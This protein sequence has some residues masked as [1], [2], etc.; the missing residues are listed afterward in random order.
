MSQYGTQT[1]IAKMQEFFDRSTRCLTEKDSNFAP[2]PG[3]HTVAGQVAHV[4][5]TVDW[6][7]DAAFGGKGFDMDFERHDKQARAVTSLTQARA[8]LAK[9]FD[10]LKKLAAGVKPEAMSNPVVPADSPILPA[11]TP[12][13]ILS[14]LEEHTAHHRGALTVY[15]R[16]LGLTPAMPY[17]EI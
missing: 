15:S 5:L 13:V 10:R 1:W 14:A 4:A 17:M 12:C 6:F 7:A 2:K 16:L 8:M 11:A 3:M 9:S